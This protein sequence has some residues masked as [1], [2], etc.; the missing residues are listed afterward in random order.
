MDRK[1]AVGVLWLALREHSQ[2][3]FVE[4]A[5]GSGHG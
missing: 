1:R 4:K 5:G 3:V 2:R